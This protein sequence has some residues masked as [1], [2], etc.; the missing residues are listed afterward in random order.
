[1]QNVS[2]KVVSSWIA[3]IQH[4]GLESAFWRRLVGL[5]LSLALLSS[6]ASSIA[7]LRPAPRA[8]D[9]DAGLSVILLGT[10]IPIP[11]PAR[12]TACTAVIAGDR[13]FLVDTGRNCLVP[14]DLAGIRDLDGIFYTHFHSDHF[15]GLGEILLNFGVAGVD[16]SIPIGGPD[17]A[18]E[19]VEG[20]IATYRLDLG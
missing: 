17:G 18:T 2:N 5:L 20:I 13:V 9:S 15:I 7:Q 4:T 12:A 10:G 1:M 6:A 19:V 16:K 3:P 14:L 11:N 8:F